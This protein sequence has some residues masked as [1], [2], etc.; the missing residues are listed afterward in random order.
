[1]SPNPY[2]EPPSNLN[3][4]YFSQLFQL[5]LVVPAMIMALLLVLMMV[6]Q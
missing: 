4:G 3:Y 6:H 2:F 5:G 1:M